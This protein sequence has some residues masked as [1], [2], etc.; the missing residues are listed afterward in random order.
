[1]RHCI[2]LTAP[3]LAWHSTCSSS[4][5]SRQIPAAFLIEHACR[6]PARKHLCLCLQANDILVKWEYLLYGDGLRRKASCRDLGETF[7][8]LLYGDDDTFFFTD[9]VLKA[10]DGLDP[11]M[12]YFLTGGALPRVMIKFAQL[13]DPWRHN[14]LNRNPYTSFFVHAQV[15]MQILDQIP[16]TWHPGLLALAWVKT[17]ALQIICGGLKNGWMRMAIQ[18]RKHIIHISLHLC[19]CPATTAKTPPPLHFH[20][21]GDAHVTLLSC[22]LPTRKVRGH[23]RRQL[24]RSFITQMTLLCQPEAY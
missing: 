19:V 13:A 10:V 21:Q 15:Q 1:M 8:W 9:A 24:T 6:F 2:Y 23:I 5:S 12:P 20:T 7:K 22:V 14:A 17:Y 4:R 11:H 16:W 3:F 18:G